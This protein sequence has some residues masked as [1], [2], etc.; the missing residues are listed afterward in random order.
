[1]TPCGCFFWFVIVL[2]IIAGISYILGA[3]KMGDFAIDVI[4]LVIILVLVTILIGLVL[5]LMGRLNWREIFRGINL[6]T[7]SIRSIIPI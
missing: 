4:R 6:M 5:I 1:M 7:T 2:L 3:N